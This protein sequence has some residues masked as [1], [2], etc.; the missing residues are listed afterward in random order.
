MNQINLLGW[1]DFEFP[2]HIRR[3]I[4]T[5]VTVDM[6]KAPA[7]ALRRRLHQKLNRHPTTMGVL[8]TNSNNMTTALTLSIKKHLKVDRNNGVKIFHGSQHHLNPKAH[9][10][11]LILFL[12]QHWAKTVHPQYEIFPTMPTFDD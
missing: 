8:W 4:K 12:H 7:T 5:T 3:V 10:M 2:D 6:A 9:W 11:K 1:K